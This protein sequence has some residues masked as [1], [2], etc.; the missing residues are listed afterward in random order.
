[1]N[2]T[3]NRTPGHMLSNNGFCLCSMCS[4]CY[5]FSIGGK[6]CPA[7]NFVGLHVLTLAAHFWPSKLQNKGHEL[8]CPDMSTHHPCLPIHTCI[9]PPPHPHTHTSPYT[10]SPLVLAAMRFTGSSC[11]PVH[12]NK[13]DAVYSSAMCYI[14]GKHW[15]GKHI[16]FQSDNEAVIT[17]LGRVIRL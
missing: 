11:K 14:W 15:Q 2:C 4:M 6:F 3:K 7:S 16:L 1:M 10:H 5:C 17:A 13:G 8:T 9:L 12:C